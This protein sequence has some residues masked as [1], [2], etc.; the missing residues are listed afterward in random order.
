[1]CRAVPGYE[2]RGWPSRPR[3]WMLG[4]ATG[5][6]ATS[7]APSCAQWHGTFLSPR[8]A[9]S[10]GTGYGPTIQSHGTG[11]QKPAAT[12]SLQCARE[13]G[14]IV[15]TLYRALAGSP[16]PCLQSRTRWIQPIPWRGRP[17]HVPLLGSGL[18]TWWSTLFGVPSCCDAVASLMSQVC[19]L[20]ID[21][22]AIVHIFVLC[23]LC[24]AA[25]Q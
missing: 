20:L 3:T 23:C 4:L 22:Y 10:Y 12:G 19:I 11:H 7:R 15:N 24:A 17:L 21:L 18:E 6:W 25:L 1:L 14:E 9:Q 16:Q 8:S 5:A 2:E 13:S